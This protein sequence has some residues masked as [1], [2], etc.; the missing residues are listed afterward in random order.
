VL[1]G[2]SRST[3][4]DP[5]PEVSTFGA[6]LGESPAMRRLFAILPRLAASD[7]TVLL[8]GETGTG[9]GVV[10]E[11][12]HAASPRAKGPLVHVDCGAISGS[13]IEAELFGHQRGAFTGAI[14][15]R[16]GALAAA[17][18]GTVFLDEIGEL[19]LDLQPRL[20]RAIEQ[21]V[22]KPVGSDVPV[23]LDVR[24]IAATHRDLRAEVQR[25]AF[26]QD[27]YFRLDIVRLRIPPLRER[28]GDIIVLA[29]HFYR[30]MAGGRE[31][32]AESL[33]AFLEHD[34]PGNVR[35]LRNEVE[36]AVLLGG[37][38][39]PAAAFAP[40]RDSGDPPEIHDQNLSF[41]R[42]KAIAM[43]RW[44]QRYVEVLL[45]RHRN[46]V[47]AAARQAQMDRNHLSRLSRRHRRAE[48][49]EE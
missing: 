42:A 25:G 47:T 5:D 22:I 3:E 30:Q 43:A 11:A 4:L 27:L 39:C 20:L 7:N 9:K 45:T 44:E 13:L 28:R 41:R 12:I 46:N 37:E 1:I 29:R 34:W 24:V 40:Q 14:V 49:P 6:L 10:A 48:R 26:R 18:G 8:Q 15:S 2:D 33:A 38:F 19:P 16:L 32:T 31:P 23:A 36:R 35:E 21:R 17:H